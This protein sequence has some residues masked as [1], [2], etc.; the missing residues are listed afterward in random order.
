MVCNIMPDY[1]GKVKFMYVTGIANKA[2]KLLRSRQEPNARLFR[3]QT[4]LLVDWLNQMTRHVKMLS[5]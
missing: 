5:R 4:I 2:G 1:R 3:L